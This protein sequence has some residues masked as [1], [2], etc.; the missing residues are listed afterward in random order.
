MRTLSARHRQE[1]K[2]RRP[3]VGPMPY[4]IAGVMAGFIAG[5]CAIALILVAF[6][7]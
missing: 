3:E 4:S 1:M 5:L 7:L 2:A 6:R